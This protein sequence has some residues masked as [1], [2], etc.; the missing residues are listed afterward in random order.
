MMDKEKLIA[1]VVGG[2]VAG[3]AIGVGNMLAERALGKYL[4]KKQ[5]KDT[6][7]SDSVAEGVAK[8]VKQA[9]IEQDAQEYSNMVKS[10]QGRNPRKAVERSM[11]GRGGSFAGFDGNPNTMGFSSD[12][13]NFMQSPN[14]G[15]NNF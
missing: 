15:L 2:I 5:E 12:P 3:F 4:R 7:I 13:R 14:G 9:K 10:R 11:R 6:T 1:G 8:G